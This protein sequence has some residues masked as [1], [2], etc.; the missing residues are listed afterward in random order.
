MGK[1]DSY[2]RLIVSQVVVLIKN[3]ELLSVI[4]YCKAFNEK[5]TL[6]ISTRLLMS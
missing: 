5:I 4:Y 2:E 6:N 1:Y 3:E